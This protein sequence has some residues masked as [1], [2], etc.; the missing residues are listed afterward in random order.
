VTPAGAL[1]SDRPTSEWSRRRRCDGGAPRR[2]RDRASQDRGAECDVRQREVARGDSSSAAGRLTDP[3]LSWIRKLVG[4]HSGITTRLRVVQCRSHSD[5]PRGDQEEV[6]LADAIAVAARLP[7]HPWTSFEISSWRANWRTDGAD[8][9][10]V[11]WLAIGALLL[12]E[13]SESK[14]ANLDCSRRRR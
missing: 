5:W 2:I 4:A 11:G 13:G 7:L 3:E 12:S 8:G 10:G 9:F 6:V 1:T 14:P